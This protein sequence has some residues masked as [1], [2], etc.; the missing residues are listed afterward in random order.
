[1]NTQ[2][3]FTLLEMAIVLVIVGLLLGGLFGSLG[4]MQARQRTDQTARQ[5]AEIREAL[6]GY[7]AANGRLPCPAAPATPNTTVGAGLARA[8]NAGGCVGGVAGVLPWATLGLPEADAWGRRFTYR[9]APAF[10]RSSTPLTLATAGNLNVRNRAAVL[11]AAQVPVVVISHGANAFGSRGPGGALAGAGTNAAEIENSDG[12]I[13]FVAD[14]PITA[15]DDQVMWLSST[16]LAGR[17]L[18]AGVLP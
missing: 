13:D 8:P 9:V 1:M 12:D 5:L 6:I 16:V 15:Y 14:T 4:A 18:Q 3:G 17:L 2:R 11:L 7:A 10:A